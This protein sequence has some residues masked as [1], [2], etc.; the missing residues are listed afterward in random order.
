MSPAKW[1]IAACALS[2]TACHRAPVAAP[3]NPEAYGLH[4]ALTPAAGAPLQR[5]ELPAAA[6]AAAQR[7]DLGD[8]RVFDGHG[9][10]VPLA[11]IAE[12]P[13][14]ARH[15]TTVPVYPITG[16]A[17]A[18]GRDGLSIKV[19]S[20]GATRVVTL[21]SSPTAP[22]SYDAPAAALLDTR[23]LHEP[24]SGLALNIAIPTGQPVTLNLLTS[25]NLKDW[26]P[27]AQKVLFRP[28]DGAGPLGG[29]EIALPGID[30]HDRYVGISWGEAHGITLKA[31]HIIT[32]AQAP[33]PQITLQTRG[34]RLSNA[35][36]LRFDLAATTTFS[37]MR[38]TE[39]GPDG[40]I[41]VQLYG[42]T[43][44]QDP[45]T[46]LSAGRLE[47]GT[48]ASVLDTPGPSMTQFKVEADSRT[49]GFSAAP[50][51]ELLFDPVT[52][53]MAASGTPP[54]QLAVGQAAAPGAYLAISEIAPQSAPAALSALPAAQFAATPNPTITLQDGTQDGALDLRK[55]V[56]WGALL[57][58]TLVL[59]FTAIKLARG[60][61]TAAKRAS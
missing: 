46:L 26:E 57:L 56:L 41:P 5:L 61:D 58:A 43:A 10:V 34:A 44:P 25:A 29:G 9:K 1:V 52:L 3:A 49:A 51:V 50:K 35:H 38:L 28:T 54:Y 19:E 27:L 11:R 31:A 20:Q 16:A 55:L 59:A 45:W 12:T 15:T 39:T 17:A 18:L 53:L 30:L 6:L 24:A 4:I 22:A 60:M 42:R 21:D 40:V 33:P 32:T 47:S 7:A 36:E 48:G 2:A 23:A 13:D 14:T 8:V 37:A